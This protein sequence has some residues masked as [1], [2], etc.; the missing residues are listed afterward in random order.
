ML[1]SASGTHE[2]VLVAHCPI[3][4]QNGSLVSSTAKENEI[5]VY[6]L[7]TGPPALEPCYDEVSLTVHSPESLDGMSTIANT[8]NYEVSSAIRSA[9][10]ID[11]GTLPIKATC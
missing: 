9:N 2:K 1:R 8:S 5:L 10:C 11:D 4:I 3:Q 7:E 6:N